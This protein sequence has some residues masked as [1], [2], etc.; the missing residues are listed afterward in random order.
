MNESATIQTGALARPVDWTSVPLFALRT[1][2]LGVVCLL[3]TWSRAEAEALRT[4][5]DREQLIDDNIVLVV[6]AQFRLYSSHSR[7]AWHVSAWP[8]PFAIHDDNTSANFARAD[9]DVLSCVG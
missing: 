3:S 9:H 8:L 2:V 6:D 5:S 7:W 4:A 1:S